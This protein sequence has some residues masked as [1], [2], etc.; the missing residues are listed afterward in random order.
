LLKS[1]QEEK[2]AMTADIEKLIAAALIA[3]SLIACGHAMAADGMKPQSVDTDA[4]TTLRV[5]DLD[6]SKPQDVARHYA[7]VSLAARD[8]CGDGNGRMSLEKRC[9]AKTIEDAVSRINRPTLTALHAEHL[10]RALGS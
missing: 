8:I 9:I 4:G 6:L 7:R 5:V 2:N 1:Q 3:A 10:K